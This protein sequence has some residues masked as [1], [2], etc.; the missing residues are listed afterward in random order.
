MISTAEA[1][2]RIGVSKNTLLRWIAEGRL[3]DVAR[4]WRNWRVWSEDD[5]A[6]ARALRDGLHVATEAAAA[7][8]MATPALSEVPY[9]PVGPGDYAVDL[10]RLGEGREFRHED[11]RARPK[12]KVVMPLYASELDSLGDARSWRTGDGRRGLTSEEQRHV[13]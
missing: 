11:E 3:T 13:G 7:E 12:T 10:D 4:D 5:I 8:P 6:R 9:K 2:A 1:A